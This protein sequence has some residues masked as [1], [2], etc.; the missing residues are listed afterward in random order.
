MLPL[1][2]D[3]LQAFLGRHFGVMGVLFLCLAAL[4]A[5]APIYSLIVAGPFNWQVHQPGFRDGGIEAL[6]ATLAVACAVMWLRSR[7]QRLLA[8]CAVAWLYLRLH[9]VDL[10]LLAAI[11]YLE[12]LLALGR[13]LV[14]R[15]QRD[16]EPGFMLHFICGVGAYSIL[17]VLLSVLHLAYPAVLYATA[18]GIGLLAAVVTRHVPYTYRAMAAGVDGERMERLVFGLLFVTL[19]VVMAKTKLISDYDSQWY[20]LRSAYVLEQ[21]GSIFANLGLAHFVFYYPK[22]YEALIL[23][24]CAFPDSSYPAALSALCYVLML[25]V[26]HGLAMDISGDQRLA[27]LATLVTG[28]V[29]VAVF[30]SL[31]VKPD[32]FTALV[33][34]VAAVYLIRF[35]AD[36]RLGDGF[37]GAGALAIALCG[38]LTAVPFGGFMAIASAFAWALYLRRRLPRPPAQ[39]GGQLLAFV[40]GVATFAIF[41]CRTYVL[42][43]LP[44]VAPSFFVTL[45]QALGLGA[46]FPYGDLA[47]AQL[48]DAWHFNS[49][50]PGLV[51]DAL[52]RPARLPHIDY[53]WIGNVFV[54]A[55]LA[56]ALAVRGWWKQ[57]GFRRPF[58]LMGLPLLLMTLFFIAFLGR[59]YGGDGNYY[60]FPLMLFTALA[61]V[62]LHYAG[63]KLRD[64]AVAGLLLLTAANGFI[65]FTTT[66]EWHGG[67]AVFSGDLSRSTFDGVQESKAAIRNE[68]AVKIATLMQQAAQQGHCTALAD[69]DEMGLF[70][71]PCAVESARVLAGAGSQYFTDTRA[72]SDYIAKARFDFLMVPN[73]PPA[74]LLSKVFDAYARLPGAV[75]TDDVLYSAVDLR[76]VSVPLPLLPAETVDRRPP[77]GMVFLPGHFDALKAT[78]PARPMEPWRRA[79]ATADERL[80]KYLDS[81]ALVISTGTTVELSSTTLPFACPGGMRFNLGFLPIDQLRDNGDTVLTVSWADGQSGRI[82]GAV[83]LKAPAQGFQPQVV[84]IRNCGARSTQVT[85]Y[86][87][88]TPGAKPASVVMADPLMYK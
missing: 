49:Q 57:P 16:G 52:L 46:H 3:R 1:N 84:A 74:T 86:A 7:A 12:A 83:D 6:A 78:A 17:V 29:P 77:A 33:L 73:L 61:T 59:I 14:Y 63:A 55:G 41:T 2:T 10:P 18:L 11:L 44:Y 13:L 32:F 75:R 36:G 68:G 42:T 45:A 65:W 76:Q 79:F 23:P 88:G 62:S 81:D 21:G 80:K 25:Y 71:L 24:L 85:L 22:L 50:G 8:C 35:L 19:L 31:L 30:T 39:A 43:G 20:G 28:W 47:N 38:K 26:V 66:P 40:L 5:A 56:A 58:L 54:L 70:V 60:V 64:G 69:G 4:L 72:L 9:H 67:T 37:A 34:L 87:H 51:F 48:G 82:L 15:W 53:S 27:A